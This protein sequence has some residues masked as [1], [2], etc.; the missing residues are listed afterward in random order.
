LVTAGLLLFGADIIGLWTGHRNLGSPIVL[1]WLLLPLFVIAPAVPLQM[2]CIYGQRIRPQAIAMVAQTLIAIPGAVI[3]GTIY[4]IV[5]V[6]AA[7]AIGEI[8]AM[9]ILA[10]LITARPLGIRY[11]P[12][13]RGCA[14][15]SA[16]AVI[17]AGLVGLG[18]RAVIEPSGLNELIVELALWAA[19][20]A[21]PVGWLALPHQV[22]QLLLTF[23]RTR[24][25]GRRFSQ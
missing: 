9:G 6:V 16:G 7:L 19:F 14:I 13:V 25:Y 11:W 12:L 18:V 17:W 23:A 5:G 10:P 1:A 21:F 20:G 22:R 4:G 8:L 15:V 3:A 2:L 24:I